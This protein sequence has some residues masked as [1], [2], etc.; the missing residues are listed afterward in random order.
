V[1][2]VAASCQRQWLSLSLGKNR[3]S[4]H[5]GPGS[6]PV[7]SIIHLPSLI[8]GRYKPVRF[9]ARGGMGVVYEV[10]HVNT[11]EHLALKL[12][13]ARVLLTPNQARRFRQE[14]RIHGLVKS[15]HLVRV[16][17]ADVAPELDDTPFLVMEL[18]TGLDFE[19]L[20][21]TR[22]PS[23]TEIVDWMSQLGVALDRAHGQGVVH[24]DLKPENL[25]LARR[26]ELPDIVKILD[27]GVAKLV[28]ENAQ[29]ATMT[30][31]ILGTPR[32]MA[33]EQARG[34]KR[35][36][37]AADRFAL[38]LIAFRLLFGR[39]YYE[40][41]SWVALLGQGAQGPRWRPSQR[42][43][44]A[45]PGFD[46]WFA[47]ACALEPRDRFATCAEQARALAVLLASGSA[48][49]SSVGRLLRRR[50][51]Q[52]TARRDVGRTILRGRRFFAAAIAVFF[53]FFAGSEVPRPLPRPRM[54]APRSTVASAPAVPGAEL[55]ERPPA[56]KSL[57]RVV[58]TSA[59]LGA[60]V[61]PAVVSEP[62]A[63]ASRSRRSR[64]WRRS[65]G[66]P[67]DS[68]ASRGEA[69]TARPALERAGESDEVPTTSE[70]A[71]PDETAGDP[72][73]NEP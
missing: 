61:H 52:S 11:G 9:I 29:N 5:A 24:R 31:Q 30:G 37:S 19:R 20:C 70:A 2:E 50:W 47:K 49:T 44:A 46:A 21:E 65:P 14:A 8:G 51:S 73:W 17:D 4:P 71:S 42:V 6:P 28:S 25:F 53:V 48:R 54:E 64:M 35:V 12:M 26:D 69:T 72:V 60:G 13:L 41:D 43:R 59:W 56:A 57:I 36:S 33:P 39:P 1:G 18:L 32:Y 7:E 58:V 55:R 40:G 45:G 62:V 38:G 34:A 10:V 63:S 66:S 68:P 67:S 15:E 16:V 27:F 3:P 22:Q 23:S